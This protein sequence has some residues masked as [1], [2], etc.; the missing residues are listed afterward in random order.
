[1]SRR[2]K[3]LGLP[4]GSVVYTG[5]KSVE[6]VEIH[7]LTYD[8]KALTEKQLENHGEI[9]FEASSLQH[10]DWYDIRGVHDTALIEQI[11]GA[12]NVHT[13]ILE[14]ITNVYQRPKL[15]TY[16]NG[17]FLIL[18]A[19]AFDPKTRKAT[20]EQVAI[21]FRA[22]LVLSFQETDSD[23][24]ELVRDRIRSEKGRIRQRGADYLAY[25]LIDVLVD[26]FFNV[27]ESL[28]DEIEEVEERMLEN[29]EARH[30]VEIHQ[31]KKELLSM[32]K[33]IVPLREAISQF[34]KS[35]RKSVV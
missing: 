9:V 13:L 24:F 5:N 31:L 22:G 16:D 15:D 2:R 10:L 26:N 4:P 28:G 35:D 34:A 19:L 18:K 29:P 25:A 27:L 1:M 7:H 20:R 23:L 32:R 17:V 21:F 11:G 30:K 6:K 8:Q 14:D 33:S 12:Y 3:S